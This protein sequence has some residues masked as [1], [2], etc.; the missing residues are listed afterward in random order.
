MVGGAAWLTDRLRAGDRIAS[1]DGKDLR[2]GNSLVDVKG[3][4]APPRPPAVTG[5]STAAE[6]WSGPLGCAPAA[7]AGGG[8]EQEGD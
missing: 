4:V 7:L 6:P 5:R 2:G 8:R 1:V 3:M